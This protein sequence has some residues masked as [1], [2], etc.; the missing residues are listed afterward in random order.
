MV[1]D[2]VEKFYDDVFK[3]CE[4]SRHEV[5][6]FMDRK[7]AKRPTTLPVGLRKRIF[8]FQ[9][10]KGELEELTEDKSDLEKKIELESELKEVAEH[11]VESAHMDIVK[12]ENQQSTFGDL[13]MFYFLFFFVI[14]NVLMRFF[15]YDPKL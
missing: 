5:N 11:G 4:N 2:N 14:F 8:T 1:S 9:N 3:I 7:A 6:V 13:L 15:D 10:G 12:P